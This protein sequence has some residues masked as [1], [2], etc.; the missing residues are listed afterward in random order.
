MDLIFLL[1]RSGANRAIVTFLESGAER[2]SF[3]LHNLIKMFNHQHKLH[4][5]YAVL[6]VTANF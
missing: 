6:A 2:F 3:G 5:L 4:F 1:Y